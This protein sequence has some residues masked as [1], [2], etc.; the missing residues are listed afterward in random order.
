MSLARVPALCVACSLA[1]FSSGCRR[2]AYPVSV[3][4]TATRPFTF[5]TALDRDSPLV[6]RIYDVAHRRFVSR[7]ELEAALARA[8]FILLG[9]KHD[10]PDHH[11]LQASL[12]DALVARGRRPIVAM[13]MLDLDDQPAV[14]AAERDH[15][16]DAAAFFQAVTWDKKGW[17]PSEVYAPIVEAAFAGR[18]R[19]VAANLPAREARAIAHGGAAGTDPAVVAELDLATPMPEALALSLRTE[20]AESH[21][22]MLPE[23][24]L[25]PMALAQRA[26][27]AEM[28]ERMKLGNA[29]GAIL[30]AGTG[31]ARKDRGVPREL[32][33]L[34]E[35]DVV[36]LAFAEVEHGQADPERYAALWHSDV[37]PFDYAW[38]TPRATDED[39]CKGMRPPR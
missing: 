8:H 16:G 13:E 30:I 31:H 9:E 32:A 12:L 7:E 37:L 3:S 6:G 21:C 29:S 5:T 28:A 23:P 35:T 11:R 27:D 2:S 18:L 15:P 36:A 1:L 10:N 25:A 24:M 4:S 22:G 20:L 19:I 14:D 38:F 17:P 26:R 34:G 39:A 33:R